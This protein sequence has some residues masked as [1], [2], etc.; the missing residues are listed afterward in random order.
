MKRILI[1]GTL[2]TLFAGCGVNKIPEVS[3]IKKS[4]EE[5]FSECKYLKFSDVEKL[6]G[7]EL[8]SGRY[9]VTQKYTIQILPLSGYASE[10]EKIEETQAKIKE[11]EAALRAEFDER[12]ERIKAEIRQLDSD[13]EIVVQAH[14]E[15]L[16]KAVSNAE[17]QEE[18]E[19]Y[20]EL[21]HK[22]MGRWQEL[23]R[24]LGSVNRSYG[25]ELSAKFV[26]AGYSEGIK[27]DLENGYYKMH[28]R[29]VQEF[30][31]A[32]K[33]MSPAGRS[34]A[35]QVAGFSPGSQMS[36]LAKGHVAQFSETVTY[37]KT[38]KGWIR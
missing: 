20:L 9:A 29:A 6:N 15:K 36:A 19:R 12:A 22:K 7:R 5:Q 17:V 13:F 18:K 21:S 16:G 8:D 31:G 1:I 24:A 23:D 25:S 11:I 34:K 30:D 38:E 2:A 37:T 4:L 35:L 32:C 14:E 3:D 26:A 28:Q 27:T 33:N 10:L